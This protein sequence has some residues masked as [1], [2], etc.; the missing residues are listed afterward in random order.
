MQQLKQLIKNLKTKI[1]HHRK[2]CHCYHNNQHLLYQKI[3][4][5]DFKLMAD[6]S[7]KHS[8]KNQDLSPKLLN[9]FCILHNL[10]NSVLFLKEYFS[11][12]NGNIV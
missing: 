4:I 10:I 5:S 2:I 7:G 3:I 11:L 8:V 12:N 6:R 9:P 1:L